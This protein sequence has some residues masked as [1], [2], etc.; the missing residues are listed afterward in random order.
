MSTL[1]PACLIYW[2][3]EL[4]KKRLKMYLRPHPRMIRAETERELLLAQRSQGE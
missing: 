3:M 2:I 4:R 1:K